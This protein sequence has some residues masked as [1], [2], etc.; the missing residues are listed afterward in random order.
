MKKFLIP[1][2][3]LASIMFVACG[4][5]S[6]SSADERDNGSEQSSSSWDQDSVIHIEDNFYN[7]E[8]KSIKD[9]TVKLSYVYDLEGDAVTRLAYPSVEGGVDKACEK[10]KAEKTAD[11][12]VTCDS[13][14]I[15]SYPK[16]QISNDSLRA[17]M[18]EECLPRRLR[19]KPSTEPEI[20]DEPE[21]N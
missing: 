2:F 16:M 18:T 7:L 5:D 15:I 8:C 20:E 11:Q 6:S 1:T 14:V 19:K 13:I 3:I 10:A 9:T 12:T 4:D 21:Q 17:L